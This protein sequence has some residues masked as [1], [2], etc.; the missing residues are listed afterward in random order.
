MVFQLDKVNPATESAMLESHSLTRVFVCPLRRGDA[1][2]RDLRL[3]HAGSANLGPQARLSPNAEFL[4]TWYADLTDGQEDH[5]APRQSVPQE[6]WKQLSPHAQ[7]ITR[8]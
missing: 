3:W 7:K 1:V 8:R 6:I 2:L 4:A 5:L